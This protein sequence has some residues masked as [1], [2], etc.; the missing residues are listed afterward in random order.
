M[1]VSIDGTDAFDVDID[2]WIFSVGLGYRFNLS[3]VFGSRQAEAVP[4]K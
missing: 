1:T 2:P 4:M 3:D